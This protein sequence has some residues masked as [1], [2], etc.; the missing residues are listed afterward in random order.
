MDDRTKKALEASIT[1]WEANTTAEVS[2]QFRTGP[3]DCALCREF[4]DNSLLAPCSYC[5]VFR[6]TGANFCCG[7][8][9]VKASSA[10]QLWVIGLSE[11]ASKEQIKQL[12]AD[13]QAAAREEVEF[14]KSL[15]EPEQE[16][17]T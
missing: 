13:A 16:P 6:K 4:Q 1:K 15:R 2:Y 12:R 8:P 7:T 14:L 5:P 9:Y 17:T 11:Q 10:R 3:R